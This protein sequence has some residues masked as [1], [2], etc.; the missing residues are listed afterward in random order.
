MTPERWR[1]IQEL[2][3]ELLDLPPSERPSALAAATGD[4]AELRR[5]VAAMLAADAEA[6]H[7]DAAEAAVVRTLEHLETPDLRFGAYRVLKT[8]GRGGMGTVYLAERDDGQFRQ[9]VAVKRIRAELG[10]EH[11]TRRMRQERQILATLDH[12]SIARLLDGGMA[13]DGRPY[14][15]MEYVEGWPLDVYCDDRKLSIPARIELFLS[16]CAAVHHAHQNLILHRDVKPANVLVTT[17]GT[18]KLLDFGIAKLLDTDAPFTRA[19]TAA[20]LRLLTP[21][22]ASPEQ[23]RGEVLGT[24][25]DVY[26]LGVVL[27]LL[28]TG[29]MP[30]PVPARRDAWQQIV[31]ETQPTR[32]S[33]RVRRSGSGAEA[34]PTDRARRRGGEPPER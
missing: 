10:D 32:P 25:S 24:A 3:H 14:F 7:S 21:E 18:P 2:F 11:T 6:D 26:A 13:S 23:L 12:P 29:E 30:Y 31:S 1:R 19:E 16:V 15:V 28:L 4:D 27:Y 9:R 22:F 8:L 33:D 5:Q 34:S 17:D 20:G